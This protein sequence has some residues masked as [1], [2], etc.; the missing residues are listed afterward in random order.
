[1]SLG[2]TQGSAS[3]GRH[4][5]GPS[6]RYVSRKR[7]RGAERELVAEAVISCIRWTISGDRRPCAVGKQGRVSDAARTELDVV[8][9]MDLRP[10]WADG[11]LRMRWATM[12][13]VWVLVCGGRYMWRLP[14]PVRILLVTAEEEG[15]AV[16]VGS[17]TRPPKERWDGGMDFLWTKEKP[18]TDLSKAAS[19]RRTAKHESRDGAMV[20]LLCSCGTGLG[21]NRS[22]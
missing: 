13:A 8:G 3:I 22:K 7:T 10:V 14:D 9:R 12:G 15:V 17:V 4:A 21:I 11:A 1:M 5:I 20:E 19:A 16:A 18:S 6:L 2:R